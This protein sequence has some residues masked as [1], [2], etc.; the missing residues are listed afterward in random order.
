MWAAYMGVYELSD[1]MGNGAP[2]FVKQL[3]GGGAHYL[4]RSSACGRWMVTDEE[5]DIA[6]NRC[7]IR[8]AQA[9]NLPSEAGLSWQCATAGSWL[10]SPSLTCTEVP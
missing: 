8:S 1:V 3:A 9:S 7:H 6:D 10:L 5:I 4:F 2:R